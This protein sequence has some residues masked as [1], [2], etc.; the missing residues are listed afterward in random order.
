[1][2]YIVVAIVTFFIGYALCFRF[3]KSDIQHGKPMV[4]GG[5]VYVAEKMKNNG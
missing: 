1:M 5:D 2:G 4:L 3:F